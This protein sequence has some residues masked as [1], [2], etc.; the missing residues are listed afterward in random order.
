VSVGRR[1]RAALFLLDL[2]GDSPGAVQFPSV[3][4]GIGGGERFVQRDGLG[5]RA[6][7]LR[8]STTGNCTRMIRYGSG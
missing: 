7:G 6:L 8:P 1:F 5:D 3:A 4:A 2:R